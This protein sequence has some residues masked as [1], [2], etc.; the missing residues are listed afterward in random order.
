MSGAIKNPG[1]W[2]LSTN[3]SGNFNGTLTLPM[4]YL[5]PEGYGFQ[6]F[7]LVS[8]GFTHV[9]TCG[10]DRDKREISCRVYQANS[11]STPA[12]ALIGW[13]LVSLSTDPNRLN[14]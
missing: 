8:S 9:S 1:R 10:Q 12:L 3:A 2:S 13:R 7:A 14:N 6:T 5:P 11:N 4:P